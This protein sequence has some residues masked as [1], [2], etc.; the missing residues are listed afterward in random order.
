M[1]QSKERTR[2][3]KKKT[4]TVTANDVKTCTFYL[5]PNEEKRSRKRLFNV[6]DTGSARMFYLRREKKKKHILT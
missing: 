1:T 5:T 4:E 3:S 6:L 2:E